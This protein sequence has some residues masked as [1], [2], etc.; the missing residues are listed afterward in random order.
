M[1]PGHPGENTE[2]GDARG[3]MGRQEGPHGPRGAAES[4]DACSTGMGNHQGEWPVIL[5]G[6]WT[7]MYE[8]NP[9]GQGENAAGAQVGSAE[10]RA[11]GIAVDGEEIS[12]S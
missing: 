10:A 11:C 9:E 8:G 2:R 1:R 6:R 7:W 5:P 3:G 12:L 4:L